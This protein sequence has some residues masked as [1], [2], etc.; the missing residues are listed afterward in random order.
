MLIKNYLMMKIKNI[1]NAEIKLNDF[2]IIFTKKL[3]KFKE[4]KKLQGKW[5]N[6]NC[7]FAIYP[8]IF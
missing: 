8:V 1:E 2:K 7:S 6:Y 3:K 5:Q 4:I